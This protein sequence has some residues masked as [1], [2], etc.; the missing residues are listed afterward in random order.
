MI[1]K[2]SEIIFLV[3]LLVFVGAGCGNKNSADNEEPVESDS[4]SL[5]DSAKEMKSPSDFAKELKEIFEEAG[6][7]VKITD[8]TEQDS[9]NGE[10][11]TFVWE[12]TPTA[13]DLEDAFKKHGYKIEV[14]GT[15][16][17]VSKN[18]IIFEFNLTEGSECAQVIVKKTEG[19]FNRASRVTISECAEMKA[20][21][22][23]ADVRNH[24]LG[25]AMIWAKK[26]FDRMAVIEAKYG[27]SEKQLKTICE[28]TRAKESGFDALVDEWVR[29]LE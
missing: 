16:M 4:A 10:M 18:N 21:A 28:G 27:I 1:T 25:T 23:H 7:K 26:L 13:K 3:G 14:P 5:C 22:L 6:G 20:L 9:A 8:S 29:L 19:P 24:D 15:A 2:I 11:F 12:N 17:V